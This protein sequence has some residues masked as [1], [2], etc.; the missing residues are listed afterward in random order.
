MKRRLDCPQRRWVRK[1]TA[2]WRKLLAVW[3][4]LDLD[5]FHAIA[6]FAVYSRVALSN[7]VHGLHT[8]DDL[9]EDC[10]PAVEPGRRRVGYEKLGAPGV[11]P[12]VRHREDAR[13]V[14][15]QVGVKLVPDAVAGAAGAGPG[16]VAALDH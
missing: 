6:G 15:P 4:L 12:R 9:A 2:Y 16:R 13:L 10:V 14:V 8:L 7:G 3:D 1:V 5:G 11:R